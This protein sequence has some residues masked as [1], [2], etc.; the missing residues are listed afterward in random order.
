M[1]KIFVIVSSAL[2][3]GLLGWTWFWAPAGLGFLLLGPLLIRGYVDMFQRRKAVR[4]NFPLI[5][6]FALN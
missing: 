6:N 4:R 2:M 3:V 5:G 1:R